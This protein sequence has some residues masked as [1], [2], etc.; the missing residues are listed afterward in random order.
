M[1]GEELVRFADLDGLHARLGFC[2]CLESHR[3]DLHDISRCGLLVN[4]RAAFCAGVLHNVVLFG[5]SGGLCEG[6]HGERC[7][8]RAYYEVMK[9]HFAF[10]GVGWAAGNAATTPG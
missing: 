10:L 2:T 6:R 7:K 8:G 9:T 4:N 5:D 3:T 1:W